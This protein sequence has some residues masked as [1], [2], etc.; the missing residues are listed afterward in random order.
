MA[1]D[2][3]PS[4][5]ELRVDKLAHLFDPFDPFPIPT[6]DLAKSAEDF[7]VGWARETPHKNALRIVVHLPAA[8]ASEAARTELPEAISATSTIA[9][10]A[11][12][13]TSERCFAWASFR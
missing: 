5:I 7:I 11:S 8:E 12:L 13:A 10:S 2:A 3:P 1:P 4:T 9:P 6:R